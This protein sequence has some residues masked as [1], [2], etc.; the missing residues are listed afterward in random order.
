MK[1][2]FNLLATAALMLSASAAEPAKPEKELPPCCQKELEPGKPLT[3]GSLY[4]LETKWTSDVGREI[5]LRVLRGKPQVVVMFFAR[6]EFACPLLLHDLK[7]IEAALPEKLRDEVGFVLITFDTQRDTVEALHAFREA[8]Q[9][10]PKRWTLL[11]GQSDDVRE[12]A[13]LLGINYKQDARG[14]FAHSNLVTILNGDGEIAQQ[15]RG[16]NNA[17]DKAVKVLQQLAEK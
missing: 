16:L 11:R 3:D 14:Q 17:P 6:C 5:Q 12:L 7:Q 9:L 4:Q 15:I 10:S 13:A 1:N 2:F 8:Q